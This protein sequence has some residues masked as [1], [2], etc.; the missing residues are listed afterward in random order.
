MAALRKIRMAGL[1]AVLIAL[2]GSIGMFIGGV[3]G[4]ATGLV[5]ASAMNLGTYY[6]SDRIVL[7]MH[8][9]RPMDESERSALHSVVERL[10]DE[11]GLPKPDLYVMESETPNAFATGRN[12]EN[13]V[14]CVTT[15]LLHHLDTEEVEGVLAHELSHIKNR[16]TLIQ[17]VAGTLAGAVSLVA[18]FLFF[19]AADDDVH[20]A[21][22]IGTIIFAPLAASI[23]KLAI[24]RSREFTADAT[25]AQYTDP[26][27][28]A[29]ALR[30]IEAFASQTPMKRGARGTS[31]M[32]IVNPFRG[33][34]LS[35]LFSTHPP[36]EERV[37]RLEEM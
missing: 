8:R 34:S 25:A 10:A 17:A 16:D 2:F 28:L 33:E 27:Y 18:Q 9:A 4:L 31:H 20:P 29:S 7:R 15:G 14:V 24:S 32:F 19:F 1:F 26:S 30:R 6:F 37:K 5:M 22:L 11:A 12:P 23:L 21:V 35:R 3:G 36:T 13:A